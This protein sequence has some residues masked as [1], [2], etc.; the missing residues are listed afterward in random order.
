M[1]PSAVGIYERIGNHIKTIRA[2]LERLE[3][4]RDILRSPDFERGS[5]ETK[6]S[7]RLCVPKTSSV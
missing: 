3:G 7:G 1:D 5:L 6:P 2:T 4:R